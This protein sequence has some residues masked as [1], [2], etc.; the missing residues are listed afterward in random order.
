MSARAPTGKEQRTGLET[1]ALAGLWGAR[2]LLV[3]RPWNT[4]PVSRVGATRPDTRS[5]SG[6]E[7]LEP[8]AR[9]AGGGVTGGDPELANRCG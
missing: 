2:G 6:T 1:P 7:S 8:Q 4:V 9:V 5:L 3:T